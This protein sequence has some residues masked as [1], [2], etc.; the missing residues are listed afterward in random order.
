[1]RNK[2]FMALAVLVCAA[3]TTAGL[4]IAAAKS[5]G[6]SAAS[7]TFNAT[8]VTNNVTKTCQIKGGDTYA[9]TKA[10]YTGAAVSSDARLNGP[11][12][13]KVQSILDQTTGVGALI[14]TFKVDGAKAAGANGKIE[15]AL[16]GGMLSGYVRSHLGGPAGEFLAGLNG[17]FTGAGGFTN[18]SLGAGDSTDSGVV[19]SHGACVKTIPVDF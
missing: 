1:M 13:L 5:G 7:A 10:T 4:A 3:L 12:T 6:V 14:G 16:S 8:T 18:A 11:M 9:F 15:A 17:G 2:R 19:L